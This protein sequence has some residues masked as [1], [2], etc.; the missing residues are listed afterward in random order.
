MHDNLTYEKVKAAFNMEEL[1]AKA[2]ESSG[3]MYAGRKNQWKGKQGS[4]SQKK[5]GESGGNNSS[6][7][8]KK[9][10]NFCKKPGHI[11]AECRTKK[12][13]SEE[14]K[15]ES[16]PSDKDDK[17]ATD[18]PKTSGGSYFSTAMS[19]AFLVANPN[20]WYVDSAA[21][22]HMCNQRSAFTDYQ[23]II[24]IDV[25]VGNKASIQAIGKGTVQLDFHVD[26]KTLHSTLA[27]ILYVPDFATSLYS[28]GEAITRGLKLVKEKDRCTLYR[29][30]KIVGIA[31]YKNKLFELKCTYPRSVKFA[32]PACMKTS[33][34]SNVGDLPTETTPRP[35]WDK[36]PN[37][38]SAA[39]E[40]GAVIPVVTTNS[41]DTE[42]YLR[43][44]THTFG[45]LELWHSKL[46][47]IGSRRIQEL[48][49]GLANGIP[50]SLLNDI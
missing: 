40:K 8:G 14:L 2:N 6:S 28:T 48:A 32:S 7:G 34:A 39:G 31:P 47:H 44:D 30:G 23:P 22:E 20:K 5:T 1:K 46:G 27:D 10:C 37:A 42:R 19:A 25:V 9:K 50:S 18:K 13:M 35:S 49:K 33:L 45:E 16:K 11:E 4:A 15:T 41:I 38:I 36:S 17:K 43:L 12:K 29:D 26:G 3:A 21:T 24:P